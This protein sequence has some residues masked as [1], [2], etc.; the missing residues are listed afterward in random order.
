LAITRPLEDAERSASVLR[1][2]GAEVILEPLLVVTPAA[3]AD[4]DLDGVQAFLLTS[5][6]GA[7]ALAAQLVTGASAFALPAL[8]VGDQTMRTALGLGFTDARSAQGDVVSLAA[9]VRDSLKPADGDLLHAAGSVQA[10]NLAE[11]LEGD[12]FSVRRAVLYETRKATAF[13]VDFRA[14]LD[15]QQLEGVLFYSPRT[16]ATFATL[17]GTAT[18]QRR[19]G[20]GLGAVKAYCLSPA[21]AEALAGCSFQAVR[22]APQPTQEAL[23]SLVK[24]D[25]AALSSLAPPA[26]GEYSSRSVP[27]TTARATNH[28]D[29]SMSD[30]PTA[31]D[32]EASAE[33]PAPQDAATS[34]TPAP[35]DRETNAPVEAAKTASGGGKGKLIVGGVAVVLVGA[36]AAYASLPWWVNSLPEQVR[37][38]AQK[39]LPAPATS[40]TDAL[41]AQIAALQ[42]GLGV[43]KGEMG[44]LQ[45]RVGVL[46]DS[47]SRPALPAPALSTPDV[48]AEPATP[49]QGNGA[50]EQGQTVAM[51]DV[52]QRLAALEQMLRGAHGEMT[53]ALEAL[54]ADLDELKSSRA[55]ASALLNLSDRVSSLEGAVNH[56]ISR[57]DRALAF[58]LAVGQLRAA[59]EG[60]RGFEGELK[61]VAAMAPADLDLTALTA[62]FA[63]RAGDGVPTLTA[64]QQSFTAI[65]AK[66]I[67]ASALPDDETASWWSRTVDRLLTVVTIRRI[68]GDAVGSGPAAVVSRAEALLKTGALAEAISELSALQGGPADVLAPWLDQAKARLAADT[69]LNDLTGSALA[70]VTASQA[71]AEIPAETNGKEG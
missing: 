15:D 29:R 46:E 49:Q 50:A 59:V 35:E 25:F 28:G 54:Q 42:N 41:K 53:T 6:N 58:L 36:L 62:G 43:V 31:T 57:Q 48:M 26:E 40:E 64:L 33:T 55:S 9:L 5:A 24:Q 60:G 70:A 47:T 19:Q 2:L 18:I 45:S 8:C 30:R 16:A 63:A 38:M 66:V 10:G 4:L 61:T 32:A 7:R 23:F 21:V 20:E 67:R 68:D 51:G 39:L 13:S 52:E 1:A 65:G 37:P 17:A 11:L 71:P 69:A 12:G 22:V 3:A 14:A 34:S 56:A 44:A 27:R